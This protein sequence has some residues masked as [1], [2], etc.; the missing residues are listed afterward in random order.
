MLAPMPLTTYDD[1]R[2]QRRCRRRR[3]SGLGTSA[4]IRTNPDTDMQVEES[5][6]K[7]RC[8]PARRPIGWVRLAQVPQAESPMKEYDPYAV[9]PK[10]PFPNRF[11]VGKAETIK[12]TMVVKEV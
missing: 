1:E 3:P 11:E 5:S 2:H 8:P 12:P 7:S 4:I 10:I 6:R 9:A